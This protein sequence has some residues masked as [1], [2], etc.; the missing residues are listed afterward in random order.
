MVLKYWI[1]ILLNGD[2]KIFF[3]E[4]GKS[5]QIFIF[6]NEIKIHNQI[7]KLGCIKKYKMVY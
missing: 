3:N 1:I 4:F 6:K 7:I 5:A 2:F